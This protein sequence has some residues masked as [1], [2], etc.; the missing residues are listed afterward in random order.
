M[1]E[2]YGLLMAAFIAYMLAKTAIKSDGPIELLFYFAVVVW[3]MN[4]L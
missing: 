4:A 3:A 1:F 2:G